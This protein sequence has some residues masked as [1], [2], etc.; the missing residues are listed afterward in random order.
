[1]AAAGSAD[2]P[3]S[4]RLPVPN[5]GTKGTFATSCHFSVCSRFATSSLDLS[6]DIDES[7]LQY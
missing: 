7:V 2:S 6:V 4:N 1:M 3:F 5:A